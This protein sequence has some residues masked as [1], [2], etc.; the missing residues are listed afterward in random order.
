MA[1]YTV[2]VPYNPDDV[3][4]DLRPI[5]EQLNAAFG[6]EYRIWRRTEDF[7]RWQSAG[8]VNPA[9]RTVAVVALQTGARRR[10][11]LLSA[12]ELARIRNQL[13]GGVPAKDLRL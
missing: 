12:A 10:T 6:R 1:E 8:V 11:K 4:A 3:D 13:V 5:F 2:D 7:G 9:R